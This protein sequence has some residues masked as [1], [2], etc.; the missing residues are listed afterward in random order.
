MKKIL[1]KILKILAILTVKRYKPKIIGITG[2]VGKTSA[3]DAVFVV[4][5][6]K[7]N[8]RKS[9]KSFNNEI[10]LPLTILGMESYGNAFGWIFGMFWAILDLI[11]MKYPEILI[12]EFGVDKP[13]DME[14]LLKIAKPDI[15]VVTTI[16]KLPVH[17]ENFSSPKELIAEKS[18]IV[19]SVEKNGFV[20]L[21]T[22]DEVCLEMKN[23]TKAN[24]FMY[25]LAE[26]TDLKLSSPEYRESVLDDGSAPLGISFK[27]EHKGS[28]VPVRLDKV[29]G[30]QSIYAAG[31]ACAV[32]IV[33]GLNLVEISESLAEYRNPPGRLNLLDGIKHSYILDDSYNSAPLS[34][35]AALDTLKNLKAKRKIAILGNMMEL[36]E[37]TEYAHR[38]IGKYAASFCDMIITVGDKARFIADEAAKNGFTQNENLFS[39]DTADQLVDKIAALVKDHDLILVKGSRTMRLEIVTEKILAYPERDRNLIVKNN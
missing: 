13:K 32:G 39:L 36:G 25:G 18:K 17:I 1:Q 3:K 19:S 23:K 30:K 5:N 29:Y 10:G 15:A 9:Q 4:L 31:V 20:I 7:F 6:K 21:N 12:L 8:V 11:Y 38:T 34:A 28:F 14:Y 27:A 16:G 22:D 24:V 2:N 37:Y 26:E 35:E 33:L